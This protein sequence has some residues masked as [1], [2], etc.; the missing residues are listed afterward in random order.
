[1]QG[2]QVPTKILRIQFMSHP[3]CPPSVNIDKSSVSEA[4]EKSPRAFE[5]VT[6]VGMHGAEEAASS[7]TLTIDWAEYGGGDLER[8]ALVSV[9]LRILEYY[10]G[11]LFLTTNRVGSMDEAFKSRIHMALYYPFLDQRQT[12]AIWKSQMRRAKERLSDLKMDEDAIIDYA[13]QHFAELWNI[14]GEGLAW[15]GRQIRNA[16]QSALA[17]AKHRSQDGEPLMLKVDDFVSVAKASREFDD[18]LMRVKKGQ[19]DSEIARLN[20]LREDR[21]GISLRLPTLVAP[22]TFPANPAMNYYGQQ[23]QHLRP[24]TPWQN[25]S[26]AQQQGGHFMTPPHQQQ[27]QTGYGYNTAPMQYNRLQPPAMYILGII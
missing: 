18:Y 27:P 16:F 4:P 3:C 19:R 1:M 9:F 13:M 12:I 15:N 10:E 22:T 8:N 20:M 25:F 5:I 11:L 7:S 24:S 23:Q 26:I 6:W 14:T 2:K 17:L 21:L